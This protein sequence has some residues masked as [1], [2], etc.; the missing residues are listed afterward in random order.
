MKGIWWE[1]MRRLR[2][3]LIS[4]RLEDLPDCV[5]LCISLLCI[6][7]S[8]LLYCCL[9][10]VSPLQAPVHA[11]CVIR[12]HSP[13]LPRLSYPTSSTRP[14]NLNLHTLLSIPTSFYFRRTLA[15]LNHLIRPHHRQTPTSVKLHLP[16]TPS[17]VACLETTH[18]T[19]TLPPSH[20]QSGICKCVQNL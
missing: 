17:L 5:W 20:S 11:N 16:Q 18:F 6:C 9:F 1:L 10:V 13:T 3:T 2:N 7:L 19:I 12:T 14:S 15:L 4:N 8:W